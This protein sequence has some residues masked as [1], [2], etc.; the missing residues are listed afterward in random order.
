[1][2]IRI[3]SLSFFL[4]MLIFTLFLILVGIL[5]HWSKVWKQKL[6]LASKSL[7]FST[8]IFPRS[9]SL[10]REGFKKKKMSNL[11][12]WLILGGGGVWGGSKSPTCYQVFFLLFK[13]DL[14]A[15]KWKKN[16]KIK[17]FYPPPPLTTP[18]FLKNSLRFFKE[19]DNF[20]HSFPIIPDGLKV[21]HKAVSCFEGCRFE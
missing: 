1:M 12:F 7:L 6:F 2:L 9:L 20:D 15:K 4:N 11:G 19:F 8:M 13:N 16:I 14:I 21:F 3:Q 17:N 10:L 18:L 5:F